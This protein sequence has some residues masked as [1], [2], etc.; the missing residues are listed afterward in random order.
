MKKETAGFLAVLLAS[1][2]WGLTT[3]ALKI[4]L[5]EIPPFSAVFIRFAIAALLITPILLLHP[6]QKV[7]R[8]DSVSLIFVSLFGLAFH[9]G[10]LVLGL[11]L[12]TVVTA[13]L[14]ISTEPIIDL[15]AASWFLKEKISLLNKAGIVFGFLGTALLVIRP[16]LTNGGD[17]EF[18]LLGNFLLVLSVI[19]GSVYII[20]S[21]R[22]YASYSSLTVT[23]FAF[24]VSSLAF[25]PFSLVETATHP[26]WIREVTLVGILAIL[27]SALFASFFAYLLFDWGL[28]RIK[29]HLVSSLSYITPI[30]SIA[31]GAIFLHE[32]LDP[33]FLLAGVIIL[34]GVYFSTLNK[35][36]H[37][38]R[39]HQRN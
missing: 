13:A 25:L 15:V 9:I 12:T 4:A 17:F 39:K 29:V 32:K 16:I 24:F 1:T 26:F 8:Q 36:H 18:P 27:F 22:L 38:L 3:P 35:P 33:F 10:F 37:H 14:L 31:L 6:P 21:K 20:G 34:L 19:F 5:S 2:I 7:S 30:V 11:N 28:A 23:C